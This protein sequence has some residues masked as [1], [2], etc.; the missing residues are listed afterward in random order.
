[1]ANL[2]HGI[3]TLPKISIVWVGRTNVTDR[4][5]T[6][7]RT[8]SRRHI[9]NVNLSS[10]SLK[11]FFKKDWM[12]WYYLVPIYWSACATCA[13]HYFNIES[14]DKVTAKIERCIFF[15]SQCT[16]TNAKKINIFSILKGRRLRPK[17]YSVYGF[18]NLITRIQKKQNKRN[19]ERKDTILS[20]CIIMAS[21]H[22]G[23]TTKNTG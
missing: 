9:A 17:K 6:D 10:R 5:T 7:G 22:N 1:M 12:F 4:Q 13:N 14:F 23:S 11:M 20:A 2:P 8:T 15:A 3:E 18:E 21:S 19:I 16:I